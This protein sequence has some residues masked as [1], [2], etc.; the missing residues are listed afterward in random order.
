[1]SAPESQAAASLASLLSDAENGP[2]GLIIVDHGKGYL[3][4]YAHNQS[5]LKDVGNWVN[6]GDVIATAG[7]SGGLSSATLYFEIRHQGRPQ[8]PAVWVKRG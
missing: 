6:A 8:D 7:R 3:S 1:M 4:L 5:L 2:V